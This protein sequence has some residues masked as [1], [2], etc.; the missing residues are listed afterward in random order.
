VIDKRILV[1]HNYVAATRLT[2]GS[3]GINA[4]GAGALAKDEVRLEYFM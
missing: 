2:A 4:G 3:S 1:Q